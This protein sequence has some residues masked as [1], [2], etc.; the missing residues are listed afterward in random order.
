MARRGLLERFEAKIDKSAGL[1][2]CWIW[3]GAYNRPSEKFKRKHGAGE[4][5]RPV[6]GIT[7]RDVHYA[8]RVALS[9]ADG[10]PLDERVGLEACHQPWCNNY[11]CVNPAHLRW[12]T[13]AANRADRYGKVTRAAQAS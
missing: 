7:R 4:S 13:P 3:T 6:F 1:L 5:R 11:Q 10:V 12:D 2:G 9:L 8:H